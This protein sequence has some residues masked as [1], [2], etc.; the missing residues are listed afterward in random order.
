VAR[1]REI[2]KAS[3]TILHNSALAAQ[4]K[5]KWDLNFQLQLQALLYMYV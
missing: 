1:E 5:T 3:T 2:S 4:L